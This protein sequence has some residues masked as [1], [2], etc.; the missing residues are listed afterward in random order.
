VTGRV[1]GSIALVA[2]VAAGGTVWLVVRD[3]RSRRRTSSTRVLRRLAVVSTAVVLVTLV[4]VRPWTADVVIAAAALGALGAVL[5]LLRVLENRTSPAG[6]GSIAA[7]MASVVVGSALVTAGGAAV[8]VDA[9]AVVG[10]KPVPVAHQNQVLV[11]PVLFQLFW[12]PVWTARAA[13]PALTVA[14]SFERDLPAS[15]WAAAVVH[16]GF[17]IRSFAA[18]G[19]WI[20]PHPPPHGATVSS[21]AEGAFSIE[22]HETLQGHRTLVPC[23]G[24]RAGAPPA[25][26]PPGAVVALWLAPGV[27]D[28]LGGV[29]AHGATP[30]VGR[31][32]GLAVIGLTGAFGRWGT[33]G[34]TRLASCRV[35]VPDYV[36]PTYALSHEVLESATNPYGHGWFADAPVQWS[37][38]YVL[39]HGPASLLGTAPV[40]QG[41]VADLCEPGQPDA[42]R[43]VAGTLGP[44]HMAVAPFYRPGVGCIS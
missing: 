1:L 39:S 31:P 19:C 18:G 20:D 25:T 22:L 15:G 11:H 40:F 23:P 14:S 12:G 7:A 42:G 8:V 44:S 37:A 28:G 3:G 6:W 30:W 26:L 43:V 34:C 29:S 27:Q 13:P 21:T 2:V 33:A 41:E 5:G 10:S 35:G 32:D 36:T 16:A 9:A 4:F 24:D 38:R 17:G